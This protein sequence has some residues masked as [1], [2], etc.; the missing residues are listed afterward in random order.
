MYSQP[1]HVKFKTKPKTAKI[2]ELL[3]KKYFEQ[4]DR[5]ICK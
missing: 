1:W 5:G 4:E 2:R 3:I